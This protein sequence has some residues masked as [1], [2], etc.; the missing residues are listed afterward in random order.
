MFF[1]NPVAQLQDQSLT[2]QKD[3]DYAALQPAYRNVMLTDLDGSG[4]LTGAWAQ[5]VSETG[6]PARSATDT[7]TY[8]RN[9]DRFEQVMAYYWVTQAQRYI[10]SLGFGTGKYP[11]V[12]KQPQR[13][14]INQYG[15]DNSFATDHPVDELRFGR[16]GGRCRGR[17]GDPPRVRPRDPLLAE[18]LVRERGS[19]GDQ[20]GLRRLLGCR[21]REQPRATPDPACA[22]MDGLHLDGAALP[23]EGG[24]EP[25]LPHRSDEVHHD[26]QIW[27]RALWDIRTALG[28]V[29]ADTIILDGQFDFPGTTMT[30]LARTTVAAAQSLYGKS[31]ATAV[32]K[33][34]ADRGIL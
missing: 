8:H 18:L 4:T 17:R 26:G 28:H 21:R 16:G 6:V 9:D 13:L 20:R 3:A 24:H 31:A 32:T 22:P 15:Q 25:A 5:V 12:N 14:R 29:K 11:S 1:P 30:A 19:G 2:D 23:A 7:F 34:F 27:S 10:Q 33:A